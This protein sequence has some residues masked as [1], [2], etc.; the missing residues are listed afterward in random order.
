MNIIIVGCGKIGQK[1]T[2]QLNQEGHN[3]TVIDTKYNVVQD[4]INRYDAMG[5]VG[6]GATVAVLTEANISAADLLIATTSSDELNLMTCL[7]AKKFGNCQTIARLRNPEYRK[8]VQLL[9]DDLALTMIINPEQAA[10]VEMARVLRFPTAIKID[11]F[12]KGRVE[13]LKF[14]IADDSVLDGILVSDIFAKLNCDVLVCGVERGEEAFIPRGN[15]TLRAKDVVSIIA[16]PENASF[17][18]KKIGLKANPIKDVIIAGGGDTAFYLARELMKSGIKVKIIEKDDKRCESLCHLLPNVVIINADAT[19]NDVLIEENIEHTGAFI[20][21]TNIDEE[22]VMLSLFV[23][24][25]SDAKV[26][27]KINRI[28][29]DKVLST[30]ELDTIIFPRNITAE[31][32][33]KF[34]RAKQNSLGCNI[35][36]MHRILDAKAEA[37]EFRITEQSPISNMAVEDLAL[38]DNVLI[39]CINRAGRIIAPRGKDVIRPNDTVI[40]VTTSKG[41]K[42]ITDILKHRKK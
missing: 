2:E 25:I 29:Y 41:F 1:L 33:T 30:L 14:R 26:I 10:A 40:V 35:E 42:D 3:I 18:F 39:A 21:L 16:A 20:S 4:T 17:F 13:L 38:K 23:K 12:A 6:N 31:Y 34:V 28:A 37:L 5:V 27:T 19:D 7:I 9:K 15:F 24:S 8:E 32:V 11:T 36:T 22:N